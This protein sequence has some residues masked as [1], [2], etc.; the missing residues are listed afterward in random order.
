MHSVLGGK[1]TTY[2]LMAEHASDAVCERLGVDADCATAE[3]PLAAGYDV[4]ELEAA[5]DR[6]DAVNPTSDTISPRELS[7]S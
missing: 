5:I 6:F 1:V 3:R 7:P 4:E 2:R